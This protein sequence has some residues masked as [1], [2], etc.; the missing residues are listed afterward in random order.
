MVL[1]RYEFQRGGFYLEPGVAATDAMGVSLDFYITGND[2]FVFNEASSDEYKERHEELVRNFVRVYFN[3]AANVGNNQREN[4]NAIG[5]YIV[6][7][8]ILYSRMRTSYMRFIETGSSSLTVN[9]LIID[10]FRPY[11]DIYFTCEVSF[12]LTIQTATQAE[13]RTGNLVILF[14]LHEE[15]WLVLDMINS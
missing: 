14:M 4:F 7:D 10:N 3:Y 6:T 15:R 12:D 5:G 1:Q 11:D 2:E 8:S 9:Q 13:E